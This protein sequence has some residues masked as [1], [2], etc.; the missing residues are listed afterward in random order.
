MDERGYAIERVGR[1]ERQGLAPWELSVSIKL[2]VKEQACTGYLGPT[3]RGIGIHCF[4]VRLW[5][6]WSG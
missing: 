4:P 2:D 1:V 6:F 3:E 5:R